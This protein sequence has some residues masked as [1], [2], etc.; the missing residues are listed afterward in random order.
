MGGATEK[1]KVTPIAQI[2]PA[3]Y[4]HFHSE[5][6]DA[7]DEEP[8]VPDDVIDQEDNFEIFDTDETGD[9]EIEEDLLVHIWFDQVVFVKSIVH[10]YCVILDSQG[11]GVESFQINGASLKNGNLTCAFVCEQ[12]SACDILIREGRL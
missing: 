11:G 4:P 5:D 12:K 3:L 10:L 9:E 1:Y 7:P 8:E 2:N 6:T